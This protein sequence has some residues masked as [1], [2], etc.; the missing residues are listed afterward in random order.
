MKLMHRSNSTQRRSGQ[1]GVL[2]AVMI[3]ILFLTVGL[4]ID[5]GRAY[6]TKTALGKA[7][8][9]SALA[10]MKN[11]NLGQSQATTIAQSTFNVNYGANPPVPSITFTKDVNNN[12]LVNVSATATVNS[13]FLS[14]LLG[15]KTLNV[16]SSA[17][18]TRNPLVMSLVLDESFSMTK[19]G[20]E[21]ALPPAVNNF[22]SHFDDSSDQVAM[23]SFAT[24]DSVDV[25]LAQPFMSK[26]Q[27]AVNAMQFGN[28]PNG[29]RTN[30]YA[31]M[32]AAQNQIQSAKISGSNV[33]KVAVFFTDGW[34]NT[35]KD[36]LKC[37]ASSSVLTPLLYC[38]CDPGDDNIMHLCSGVVFMNPNTGSLT[39]CT[40]E[41][42]NGATF[43]SQQTGGPQPLVPAT[44]TGMD[45]CA[46]EACYRTVQVA[47]SM[48]A[49]NTVV[50]SIGLGNA[51]N[52]PFLQQ[53]ANDPA[54]STFDA[55]KPIGEAVFAPTSAELN[56]VF[57][58]IA[59]KVLLRLTQ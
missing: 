19:N 35:I 55:S 29:Q 37:S 30:A 56:S 16:S 25:P 53:V 6:V 54:A 41:T 58:T 11:L 48:R 52:Q 5:V 47:D 51:I 13:F 14:Y 22:I 28:G 36:N 3:P 24:L 17:Q 7:L 20:G 26:I 57:E 46:A 40:A 15:S 42:Q 23:V 4:V 38:G 31:G 50:Y 21:Q 10:A 39:N 12:T 49:Q 44:P 43:P 27:S 45:N 18:A 8:D 9:A 59:S 1:L 2:F 33:Q 32:V 34:A